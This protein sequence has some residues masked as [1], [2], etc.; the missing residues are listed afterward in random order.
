LHRK[1]KGA[2]KASTREDENHQA[3]AADWDSIV[4]SPILLRVEP[5]QTLY[6]VIYACI[7]SLFKRCDLSMLLGM[8][9]M[10]QKSYHRRNKST[11]KI[12]NFLC[13]HAFRTEKEEK[14]REN[15]EKVDV[16]KNANCPITNFSIVHLEK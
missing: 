7:F 11:R 8:R 1:K 14:K 3:I 5:Q 12:T 6:S 13:G 4:F 9:K 10:L 15:T 16:S 2:E